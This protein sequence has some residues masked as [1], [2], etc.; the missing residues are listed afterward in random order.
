MFD[1]MDTDKDGKLTKQ[2]MES[3]FMAIEEK[4]TLPPAEDDDAEEEEQTGHPLI[5]KRAR[6][7][8]AYSLLDKDAD[9]GLTLD[10]ASP[11][12]IS[13]MKGCAHPTQTKPPT[14]PLRCAH[15]PFVRLG[16]PLHSPHCERHL[17]WATCA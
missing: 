2:E 15:W 8:H 9:A 6:V 4:L 11:L 5:A 13:T 17:T 14:H 16:R 3:F 1:A 10:E 12:F 7:A